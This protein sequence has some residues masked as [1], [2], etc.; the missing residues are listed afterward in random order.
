[1]QRRG[2]VWFLGAASLGGLVGASIDKLPI[3]SF[4][5]GLIATVL[6][7]VFGLLF[8]SMGWRF[9]SPYASETDTTLFPARALALALFLAVLVGSLAQYAGLGYDVR[10]RTVILGIVGALAGTIH[11]LFAGAS[12]AFEDA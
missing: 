6:A 11:G 3:G 5:R 10:F 8:I 7:W 1:M 12:D 4:A 9:L 2:A